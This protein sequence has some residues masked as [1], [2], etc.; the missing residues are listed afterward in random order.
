MS[1]HHATLPRLPADPIDMLMRQHYASIL[2]LA[3]S[4]LD[5]PDEAEDAAQET[6]IRAAAHAAGFRGEAEI[7][8]WLSAIAINVCRSEL[9]KRRT[10]SLLAKA[11]GVIHPL[12]SQP[13]DPE[14]HAAE[15]DL[16]AQLRRAVAGLDEKH[17]IPVILHYV[18]HLSVPQIAAVMETNENTIHSRL[19]HARRK[20]ARQLRTAQPEAHTL[21]QGDRR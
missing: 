10:R 7:K 15:G 2:R 21:P 14:E 18:Q 20:L 16:H 11:M 13:P 5:D 19:F 12:V 4:I 9:R 6:F 8:T 17:R 3:V 1:Q